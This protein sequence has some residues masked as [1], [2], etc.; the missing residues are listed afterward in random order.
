MKAN[1]Q[2]WMAYL[3]P[4]YSVLGLR[5]TPGHDVVR[6]LDVA[7]GWQGSPWS[8]LHPDRRPRRDRLK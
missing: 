5:Q 1:D 4:E 8:W 2:T 7:T 3:D 6:Y